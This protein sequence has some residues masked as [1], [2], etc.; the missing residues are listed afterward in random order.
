MPAIVK[1]TFNHTGKLHVLERIRDSGLS[2]DV[3]DALLIK[4]IKEWL[5][6][7]P[8][9]AEASVWNFYKE[10]LDDTVCGS[11]GNSFIM[12]LLDLERFYNAPVGGYQHEDG[13]IRNAPW[14]VKM[15]RKS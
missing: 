8:D 4:K 9:P 2:D 6:A 10:I 3:I 12:T 5:A 14:R 1:G 15:E 7:N 13:S 11:L